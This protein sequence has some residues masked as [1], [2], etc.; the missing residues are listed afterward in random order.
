M[1]FYIGAFDWAQYEA[2]LAKGNFEPS[3]FSVELDCDPPPDAGSLM[4]GMS[5]YFNVLEPHFEKAIRDA[6]GPLLGAIAVYGVKGQESPKDGPTWL[7]DNSRDLSEIDAG[8][9]FSPKTVSRIVASFNSVTPESIRDAIRE[10]WEL[11]S[12]DPKK[13]E[14]SGN[15]TFQDANEF[16]EYIAAWFMPF[17]EAAKNGLGLAISAG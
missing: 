6:L 13:Y 5:D 15:D 7:Y 12:N 1:E 3:A 14:L 4:A 16:Y 8:E 2:E 9:I 10:A 11:K 17:Q